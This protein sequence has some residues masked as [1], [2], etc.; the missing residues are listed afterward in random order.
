MELQLDLLQKS[1]NLAIC[2]NAQLKSNS[3]LYLSN[4]DTKIAFKRNDLLKIN[5][6]I[7]S[8]AVVERKVLM[9]IGGFANEPKVRGAEDFATWLRVSTVTEWDYMNVPLVEYADLSEDSLRLKINYLRKSAH[10]LGLKDFLKWIKP[11]RDF[12]LI[13]ALTKAHLLQILGR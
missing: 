3:K 12:Y 5:S 10:L 1:G 11:K 8:S 2:S 4:L 13:A 6:V 7:C 9:Q